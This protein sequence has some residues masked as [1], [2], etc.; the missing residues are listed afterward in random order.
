MTVSYTHIIEYY[1]KLQAQDGFNRIA[2]YHDAWEMYKSMGG[3]LI[4]FFK[5]N[6]EDKNIKNKEWY[7]KL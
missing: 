7:S 1:L 4:N 3:K 2:R 5:F 6:E